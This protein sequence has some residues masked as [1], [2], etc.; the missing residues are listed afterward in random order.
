M[1]I[2]AQL[3]LGLRLSGTNKSHPQTKEFWEAQIGEGKLQPTMLKVCDL[4]AVHLHNSYVSQ[5]WI[6]CLLQ[7]PLDVSAVG[8]KT[9]SHPKTELGDVKM[10]ANVSEENSF[11]WKS[12]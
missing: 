2:T 4:K 11:S 3:H 7:V 12:A 6:T 10:S 1:R 8:M 5:S 9:G